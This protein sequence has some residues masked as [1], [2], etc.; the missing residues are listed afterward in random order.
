MGR[1]RS[2]KNWLPPRNGGWELKSGQTVTVEVP[3]DYSSGRIW[4]RTGC[5]WKSGRFSCE[6]GDCGPWIDC[7]N[8]GVQRSGQ[9]PATL[10]EFTLND[11]GS[12]DYYDVSLVDGYNLKMSIEIESPAPGSGAYW[13]KNPKCSQDLN[14][15]C[16]N[17]L[18][19]LNS[20]GRV[21]GC[22]SAC[23]KFQTD[24]YCCRGAHNQPHTCRSSD[25]PFNYPAIFKKACPDAYSYA[26]D[27]H[28]STFFCRNTNYKII[29]C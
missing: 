6:T 22:V 10:A 7:S 4:A 1:S 15:I 20:N 8:G 27:D 17:E 29:F 2:N 14:Q 23:E 18:K 21:V 28:T 19:K 13:C 11:W 9:T 12:Q 5:N 25:W 24:Q 26:Y 3:K 16:P